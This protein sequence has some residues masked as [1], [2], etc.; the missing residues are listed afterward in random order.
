MIVNLSKLLSVKPRRITSLTRTRLRHIAN[1]P[2]DRLIVL[3]R[4]YQD[5]R[6][7]HFHEIFGAICY[8]KELIT[9]VKFT[10]GDEHEIRSLATPKSGRPNFLAVLRRP[11]CAKLNKYQ[12]IIIWKFTLILR[13]ES[14]RTRRHRWPSFRTQFDLCLSE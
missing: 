8:Q 10:D 2:G 13:G 11:N 6:P 7:V 9:H 4:F 1:C 12:E 5:Q 14:R 3:T